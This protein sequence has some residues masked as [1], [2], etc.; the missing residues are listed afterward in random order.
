VLS[1]TEMTSDVANRILAVFSDID[2]TMTTG[3]KLTEGAYGAMWRLRE[4]GIPFVPVTGRPA[5]WCDCIA[6]QWPVA[7]VIG[8]N[9]A[10]AFYEEDDALKRIYHPNAVDDAQARLEPVRRAILEEVPGSRVSKDQFGR[11]FDLAI[12]FCEEPPDLG[13]EAA[14]KIQ[15]IFERF[16]AVAKISSIHV[17]GWFGNYDKLQ[18]VRQFAAQRLNQDIDSAPSAFLFC[19]DS[20]NDEPMFSFFENACGVANLNHFTS[21]MASLPKYVSASHGGEGFAEIIDTFLRL[22]D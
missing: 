11:L 18:M 9:G 3:G 4:A 16:G 7:G 12:D 13:L 14:Q 1:I 20:P 5:G 6:R 2:D 22:R 17:N 10:L 21:Q 8:E 15:R 19:G